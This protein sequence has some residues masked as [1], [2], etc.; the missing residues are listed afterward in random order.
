MIYPA[1]DVPRAVEDQEAKSRFIE[2]MSKLHSEEEIEIAWQARI[3]KNQFQ[4]LQVSL[5]IIDDMLKVGPALIGEKND[6]QIL[7]WKQCVASVENLWES[8]AALWRSG[9]YA[10]ATALAI[11]TLEET[12]K[13]AVERVRLLGAEFEGPYSLLNQQGEVVWKPK[14]NSFLSHGTKHLLAAKSGALI[15]DRLDRLFGIEVIIDFLNSAENH[16]LEQL[17]QDCLYLDR[18]NGSL[19]SPQDAVDRETAA[20]YVALAG[21]ILTDILPFEEEVAAATK[22][23]QDF[24]ISAGLPFE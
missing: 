3:A 11:I 1:E 23:V 5:A 24:E 13:L 15:N 16:D 6:Q 22:R 14:G 12:A 8:S 19:H 21:E 7:D 17:K 20:R 4:G 18:K 9:R 10:P 2:A